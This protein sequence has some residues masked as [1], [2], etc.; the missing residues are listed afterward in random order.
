MKSK[1]QIVFFTV[2]MV[3]LCILFCILSS[4]Y[5]ISRCEAAFYDRAAAVVS[6]FP[7]EASGVMKALKHP[8]AMDTSS[9][10]KLLSAYGYRGRLMGMGD[11]ARTA[12]VCTAFL[13]CF[14][15]MAAL[16]MGMWSRRETRRIAGLIRYLREVEE[17]VYPVLPGTEEDKFSHLEDEIYKTVAALRESREAAL[18]GKENLAENLAD[19]SHQLKTPLTGIALMGELLLNSITDGKQRQAVETI[20]KQNDRMAEL[21]KAILTL[22][23]LDA[24]V[25]PLNPGSVSAGELL[26]AAM[27]N[28]EPLFKQR[29]QTL[30]VR[31]NSDAAIVCDM[32]WTTEALGNLLKNCSEYGPDGSVITVMAEENPIFTQIAVEDEG[33]GLTPDDLTHLFDRFYKGKQAAKGSI[34]IGLS[35]A[36]TIVHRQGG[37]LWAENRKGGGARFVIRFYKDSGYEKNI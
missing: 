1:K 6:V 3:C 5:I 25:L 7:E 16:G 4:S 32:G 30:T 9:G 15:G 21:V 23:R 36:K 17:G 8:E 14:T 18:R 31:G 29:N 13:A 34:G 24:G 37:G 35:L 19:I 28:V 11:T 27:Q 10:R 20:V 26:Y 2:G 22:S 33:P 12:M